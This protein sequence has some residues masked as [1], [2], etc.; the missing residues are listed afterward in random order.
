MLVVP[1]DPD[2]PRD[3]SLAELPPIMVLTQRFDHQSGGDWPG[4]RG[5]NI[6]ARRH[7]EDSDV[8][9]THLP[10]VWVTDSSEVDIAGEGRWPADEVLAW[11]D[12]IRPHVIEAARRA[13]AA[14][15]ASSTDQPTGE[16]P[17]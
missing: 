4:S 8:F 3:P 15:T 5:V 7:T 2:E 16:N 13:A 12:A 14:K 11:L 9:S 17:K 6:E 10:S 1:S